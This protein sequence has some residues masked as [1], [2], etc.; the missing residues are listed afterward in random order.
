MQQF[1]AA[2]SVSSSRKLWSY[3]GNVVFL[4]AVEAVPR[5]MQH[6][7]S[8]PNI[9]YAQYIQNSCRLKYVKYVSQEILYVKEGSFKSGR[10]LKQT[11]REAISKGFF[12]FNKIFLSASPKI[13]ESKLK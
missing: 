2:A 9:L 5:V 13:Y 11:L 3:R 7:T 12:I 6:R 4:S 1:C 8:A 10:I